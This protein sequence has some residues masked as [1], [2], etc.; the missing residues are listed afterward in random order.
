MAANT[1]SHSEFTAFDDRCFFVYMCISAQYRMHRAAKKSS[2]PFPFFLSLLPLYLSN[3]FSF[4]SLSSYV[5]ICVV[6]C[7]L[8]VAATTH[9]IWNIS[10]AIDFMDLRGF[11]TLTRTKYSLLIKDFV[12]NTNRVFTWYP[13]R[14][15]HRKKLR[16]VWFFTWIPTQSPITILY[17]NHSVNTS[18]IG[19]IKT[20]Y[21]DKYPG[22][23]LS[24]YTSLSSL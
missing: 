4:P 22:F 20:I 19:K 9:C 3:V 15:S 5:L 6:V 14:Q 2:S 16:N 1:N 11:A 23:A 7:V 12:V 17:S 24:P 18:F 10:L 21:T 8:T 13:K